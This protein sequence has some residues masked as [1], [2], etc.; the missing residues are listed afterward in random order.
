M[1]KG[2][3]VTIGTNS[4]IAETTVMMDDVKIGNNVVIHDYVVIFSNTIIE[5]G[6]EIF[7]HCVLAKEPKAPGCNSR[8]IEQN[9]GSTVIGQNCIL[10]PG[11]VVYKD[12]TI[13]N[14]TLLGD[15]CSIRE[16]CKIGS[17]CIL[18]RNVSVNYNTIIGDRTKI[19]D[20]SHITGDMRIGNGVFISVLVS[21][22]N[23]NTMDR[24]ADS[25]NQLGG[26]VIEDNV[27][28]GAGANI[29]PHVKIGYNS[30]VG[31]GALVTKNVPAGKVV[32]GVPAKIVRDVE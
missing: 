5:D 20:N 17:Y 26:P 1:K 32:M 3:N 14:N 30:I 11:C 31:A 24:T 4:S 9:L 29:L 18:S 25:V 6:V 21:T 8:E 15:Y 12:V 16:K 13:G 2:N 7:P 28:I 22:T 10:S 19:M 23:D 27:S